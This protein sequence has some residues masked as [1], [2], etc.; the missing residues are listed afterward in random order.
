MNT[1]NVNIC[2]KAIILGY[3]EIIPCLV[4]NYYAYRLWLA[5]IW[6][7]RTENIEKYKMEYTKLTSNLG[8]NNKKC[9]KLI[10]PANVDGLTYWKLYN[11]FK[12]KEKKHTTV[13]KIITNLLFVY[14]ILIDETGRFKYMK[15]ILIN[16]LKDDFCSSFISFMNKIFKKVKIWMDTKG[17][18][19]LLAWFINIMDTWKYSSTVEL[20]RLI[21]SSWNKIQNELLYKVISYEEI[22]KVF[23]EIKTCWDNNWVN[24]KLLADMIRFIN[25]PYDVFS[26]PYY[27]ITDKWISYFK[28]L[29]DKLYLHY[30]NNKKSKYFLESDWKIEII[31]W[32]KDGNEIKLFTLFV[33]ESSFNKN[34]KSV[35]SIFNKFINDFISWTEHKVIDKFFVSRFFIK[36]FVSNI[37]RLLRD[38]DIWE[39]LYPDFFI[40]KVYGNTSLTKYKVLLNETKLEKVE[41]TLSL[42]SWLIS[43]AGKKDE[44]ENKV[45]SLSKIKEVLNNDNLLLEQKWLLKFLIFYI[46]TKYKNKL[47]E[48]K[49]YYNLARL[50]KTKNNINLYVNS[51]NKIKKIKQLLKSK[52][53]YEY[54]FLSNIDVFNVSII[55]HHKVVSLYLDSFV[56]W[57]NVTYVDILKASKLLL[58]DE[59]LDLN[60]SIIFADFNLESKNKVNLYVLFINKHSSPNIIDFENFKKYILWGKFGTFDNWKYNIIN[61]KWYKTN[62]LKSIEENYNVEEI[63]DEDFVLLNSQKIFINKNMALQYFGIWFEFNKT[64]IL[65]NYKLFKYRII[66]KISRYYTGIINTKYLFDNRYIPNLTK[67]NKG[68]IW[69]LWVEVLQNIY[70][71]GWK[72]FDRL[73]KETQRVI[74]TLLLLDN[75]NLVYDFII[76]ILGI[77]LTNLDKEQFLE[78]FFNKLSLIW[79]D[80]LVLLQNQK[81]FSKLDDLERKKLI[82]SIKSKFILDFVRYLIEDKKLLRV[83]RIVKVV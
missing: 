37:F 18:A 66:N 27:K 65:N 81:I 15:N 11:D 54:K 61:L 6:R 12:D 13:V 67:V 39:N 68:L 77:N 5:K 47:E 8:S 62:I 16:L 41:R 64:E 83:N 73:N 71:N 10:Y 14:L 36:S 78:K 31:I 19:N 20:N 43:H 57:K 75:N 59:D 44:N 30:A 51:G 45:I 80:D 1:Q 79:V 53:L 35:K 56:L 32:E 49:Y 2:K 55:T 46:K 52:L 48:Y 25:N 76:N 17:L 34:Y 58:Y 63:S 42:T 7:L 28:N 82:K 69:Y 3:N 29:I 26:P 4:K 33:K 70:E 22:I 38:T 23:I 9:L 40:V 72:W 21:K 74:E 60:L 50:E 24:N